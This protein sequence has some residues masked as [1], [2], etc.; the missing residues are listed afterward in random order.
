MTNGK[1][2]GINSVIEGAE[3]RL[4][5]AESLRAEAIKKLEIAEAVLGALNHVSYSLVEKLIAKKEAEIA[6]ELQAIEK[7]PQAAPRGKVEGVNILA[8]GLRLL[9]VMVCCVGSAIG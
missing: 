9:P 1:V 3:Y 8:E 5:E 6:A 4:K 2:Q 7:S